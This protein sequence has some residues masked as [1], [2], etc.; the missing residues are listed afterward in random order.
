MVADH[1]MVCPGG[2]H[3]RPT[4][5]GVRVWDQ[6]LPLI[7]WDLQGIQIKSNQII[8]EGAFDLT[9]EDVDLGTKNV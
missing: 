5:I 6:K 2:R 8:V 1:G 7:G 9:T 3:G 4:H